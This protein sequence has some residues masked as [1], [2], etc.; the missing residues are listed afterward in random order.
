MKQ[1]SKRTG[2]TLAIIAG[3]AMW[4]G[5]IHAAWYAAKFIVHFFGA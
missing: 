1:L 5:A 2:W 4:Y 3:L